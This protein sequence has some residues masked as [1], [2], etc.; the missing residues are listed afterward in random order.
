MRRDETNLAAFAMNRQVFDSFTLSVIIYP[1]IAK[2]RTSHGMKKEHGQNCAITFP[3]E[4]IP[5][6]GIQESSRLRV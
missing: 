4:R 5:G 6:R 1:Q 3:L 2:L